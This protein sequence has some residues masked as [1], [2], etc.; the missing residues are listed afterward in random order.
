[1]TTE[2]F[3]EIGIEVLLFLIASYFIF[4]KSWLKE[5]GKEVAKLSTVEQLTQLKEAVKKD[6]NEKIETY[7]TQL[8]EELALKIEPLKS[9]LSK[10]NITHQIQFGYLHQERSKVVL[11]LYK[12]LQELHSAMVNWTAF[13]QPIIENAEKESQDRTN[14]VNLA[15]SDF[16][17]YYV[18]NKLF[19]SKSFCVFIDLVFK[20]YWD[21]G[22]EFGYSQ[23]RI[24]N[25]QLTEEYFKHYSDEM[26]KI[27]REIKENLPKKIDEIEERFRKILNVEEE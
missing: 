25:G 1:M 18:I 26:S 16:K 6:F 12:K 7:K 24:K 19:F 9:E 13:M 11:E 5:L 10:N 22:W 14:R 4:Y 2:K 27:S 23:E 21:K 20:E 8:S 3:I 17:N 15:I